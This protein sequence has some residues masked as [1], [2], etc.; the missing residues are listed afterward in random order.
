MNTL[1]SRLKRPW[2][3]SAIAMAILV[4]GIATSLANAMPLWAS[5]PL[6]V[7]AIL[8]AVWAPLLVENRKDRANLERNWSAAV[9][10]APALDAT[11]GAALGLI[12][13]L[14]PDQ[15]PVRFYQTH[16]GLRRKLREWASVA[17]TRPR[18]VIG[19][20]GPAGS[21]K[22]RLLL[23]TAL[24]LTEQG[25]RCGWVKPG[26]GAEAVNAAVAFDKPVLLIVDNAETDPGL[27]GMFARQYATTPSQVTVAI[28]ARDTDDW[29]HR[30]R[31]QLSREHLKLMAPESELRLP[32]PPSDPVAQQQLFEQARKAFGGSPNHVMQFVPIT[33][34]SVLL[35]QATALL[36]SRTSGEDKAN[37]ATAFTVILD[38]EEAEW[39][40]LH[41]FRGPIENLRAAIVLATMISTDSEVQAEVLFQHHP[42]LATQSARQRKELIL[43]LRSR[44]LQYQSSYLDL[45]LPSL[46][47]EHYT[48]VHL[49]A[50]PSI[51]KAL[52]SA[53]DA[54]PEPEQTAIRV[55]R[56][57]AQAARHTPAADTAL[58]A[59]ID[60]NPKFWLQSSLRAVHEMGLA[61]DQPLATSIRDTDLNTN[62]LENLLDLITDDDQIHRL[63]ETSIAILKRRISIAACD[64]DVWIRYCMEMVQLLQ[65]QG[66]Y[67]HAEQVL[68]QARDRIEQSWMT[69]TGSL[70][71]PQPV[72]NEEIQVSLMESN[73]QYVRLLIQFAIVL[74]GLGQF[75]KSAQLSREVIET[76]TKQLG[77]DH[78]DTLSSINV[79]A[80]ALQNLGRYKEAEQ[81]HRK[82]IAAHTKQLGPDHPNTL[83]RYHNLAVVLRGLGR[84]EEA[85]QLYREVIEAQTEQLGPNHLDAG[86]WSA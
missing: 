77:P 75:K 18:S 7:V 36:A 29:W 76:Q 69:H 55:V 49:A 4:A 68:K 67:T 86:S 9:T 37:P 70:K 8:A 73:E 28:A 40:S 50:S 43:A 35:I 79:L 53:T 39:K 44:Y 83:R 19:V 31:S 32:A 74:Q 62:D 38:A 84:Y 48:A 6:S 20:S 81:K 16:A 14:L 47:V 78:P 1:T 63:A 58:T 21:G 41:N 17:E 64:E 2:R 24:D 57:L 22:T 27:P 11:D 54:A 71:S 65:R 15:S 42:G 59:I 10:S 46:L 13:S 30:F 5:L 3:T 80:V 52:V 51:V 23:E 56:L 66:R 61:I 25:I 60:H 34:P 82:L 12:A 45:Y 33:T 26:R 72:A 85:E